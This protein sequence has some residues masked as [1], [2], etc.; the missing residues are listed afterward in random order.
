MTVD[1]LSAQ[2]TLAAIGDGVVSTDATGVVT[3]LNPA[4]E[5]MTGWH[6]AD[7]VGRPVATVLRLVDPETRRDLPSPLLQAMARDAT[8][9]LPPHCLLIG[10]DG[11]ETPVEDSTAP[12]HDP[13]GAVTGA[14][15]VFRHVGAALEHSR[16]M[17]HAALHDP[18]TGLPNRLL[19][20]DRI[21]S[22]LA[23]SERRQGVVAVGF[24]DVDDF[25]HLNDTAGHAAGDLLLQ[26]IAARLRAAVRQSDT[27]SRY[28]GDEFVVV[29]TEVAG[30]EHLP[31]IASALL[32]A[33]AGPHDL[34]GRTVTVSLSLGLAVAPRDG[35]DAQTL[36][37]RA[38]H[39]MYAAKARGHG[40]FA[41]VEPEDDERCLR[42][43]DIDTGS[44][45]LVRKGTDATWS[46]R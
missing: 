13:S 27:I 1:P 35:R 19:L 34:D 11:H 9:G 3:Y 44:L 5:T 43:M 25:K 30:R 39:A 26:A 20:L 6:A 38:D 4:A 32:E 14:V 18:L 36:I 7:A 37:A 16:V 45:R 28:G 12:I 24:L 29:L 15:I 10:R 8:V 42:A 21:T 17:T 23:L 40:R 2:A 22:A 31:V 41:L 33:G 46:D